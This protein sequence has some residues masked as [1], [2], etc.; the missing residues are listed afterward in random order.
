[1]DKLR[2]ELTKST[3]DRFAAIFEWLRSLEP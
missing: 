3:R 1:V 2:P